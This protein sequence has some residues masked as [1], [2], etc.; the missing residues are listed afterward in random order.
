MPLHKKDDKQF[1][2]NYRPVSLLPVCAKIFE[3]IIYNRIFEY[4]IENNLM[5][6]NQS[7]FKLGDSCIN[8][9]LAI[10]HD[11]YKSLDDGFEVKGVFLDIF[12]AFNKVWYDGLI[13]KLKQNGI[14]GKL[15]NIIKDFLDSRKQRV[16]LNGQVLQ[17][18]CL[19]VQF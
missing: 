5:T 15:L 2:K 19:K 6:E 18:G 10:T 17:Q 7:G 12:K 4:L 1:L 8:Q 9:L 3:R 14:L 11:I 13:D 16:V